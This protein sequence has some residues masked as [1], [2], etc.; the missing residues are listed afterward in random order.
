MGANLVPVPGV[1]GANAF[2]DLQ[3]RIRIEDP[4]RGIGC[5]I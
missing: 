5:S 2:V 1:T 4:G 3:R